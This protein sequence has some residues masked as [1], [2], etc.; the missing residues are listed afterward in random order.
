MEICRS[1]FVFVRGNI[2]AQRYVDKVV[3]PHILPFPQQLED[4]S[5]QQHNASTHI[6]RPVCRGKL[7]LLSWSSPSPDLLPN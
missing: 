4:P 3:E 7:N 1:R 2:N 6:T 5:F